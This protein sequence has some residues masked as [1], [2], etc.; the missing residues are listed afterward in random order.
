M[1]KEVYKCQN[2]KTCKQSVDKLKKLKRLPDGF[3]CKKCYQ[4]KRKKNREKLIEGLRE[5]GAIKRRRT[6]EEMKEAR[7]IIPKILSAIPSTIKA[8]GMKVIQK[9]K[10]IHL[11]L[12]KNERLFLYKKG[13]QNGLSSEE[14]SKRCNEVCKRMTKL[15]QEL[16][17]Q[18]KS[19]EE[20]NTKFQEEF[21]K[22]VGDR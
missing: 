19:E 17:D 1:K 6:P 9:T 2:F 14:S 15:T 3:L 10:K 20:I 8:K 7:K 18:G 11:Y 12:T 21:A 16:R 13:V 22:L 5:S 4:E